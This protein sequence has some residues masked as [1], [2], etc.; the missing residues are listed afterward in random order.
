M[1]DA[2]PL[3]PTAPSAPEPRQRNITASVG[4][5]GPILESEL[6]FT[7]GY[8]RRRAAL[9][10][11]N[12]TSP[13]TIPQLAAPINIKKIRAASL[14]FTQQE[15]R[16]NRSAADNRAWADNRSWGDNRQRATRHSR[17]QNRRADRQARHNGYDYNGHDR[18]NRRDSRPARDRFGDSFARADAPY[19]CSTGLA[20]L[21]AVAN[22]SR[23]LPAEFIGPSADQPTT[24]AFA[25]YALPLLGGALPRYT[26]LGE[27]GK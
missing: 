20:P 8:S 6:T 3:K 24:P 14:R 9:L 25:V 12:M 1:L 2:P 13:T 27:C 21:A 17:Q 19:R 7:K 23:E 22:R 16:V 26:W 18:H 4:Y 15:H 10:V 5:G 11:A